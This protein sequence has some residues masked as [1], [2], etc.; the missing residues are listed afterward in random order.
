MA[1]KDEYEVARL[2][3]DAV[4]RARC[5]RSSARAR[6]SSSHLHPPLLRALGMKRKLDA[7]AAGSRPFL[8]LLRAAEAP[9]RHAA[10]PFGYARVRRVERALIGEY[11]ALVDE[12][13]RARWPPTRTRRRGRA[14]R[15]ARLVRGY[16]DIKL[17]GVERFRARAAELRERL[18]A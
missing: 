12:R 2:H 7:R 3:L 4:E 11:R 14:L 17:A 16:E 5:R 9:A 10:R 1:Y 13:A 18:A 6:R 15:A 8:R